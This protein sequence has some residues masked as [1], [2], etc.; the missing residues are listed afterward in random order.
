MSSG[1]GLPVN[2]IEK[3]AGE[4]GTGSRETAWKRPYHTELLI[5]IGYATGAALQAGDTSRYYAFVH[6]ANLINIGN[7]AWHP[8]EIPAEYQKAAVQ[9]LASPQAPPSGTQGG[10]S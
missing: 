9:S 6:L 8:Y 3:P 2:P 10:Q 7:P 5:A 1:S 4:Q